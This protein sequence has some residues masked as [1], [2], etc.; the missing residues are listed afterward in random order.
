MP[1][2]TRPLTI[3]GKIIQPP[4]KNQKYLKLCG[5]GKKLQ[6]VAFFTCKEFEK[7]KLLVRKDVY[8]IADY[9]FLES[10]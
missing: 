6:L 9:L 2:P 5:T 8:E 7:L 1:R 10:N 3:I 4:K